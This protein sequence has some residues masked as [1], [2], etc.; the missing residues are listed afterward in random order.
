MRAGLADQGHGDEDRAWRAHALQVHVK[1][2]R[3]AGVRDVAAIDDVPYV[4]H[5]AV[6]RLAQLG[7]AR[8]EP[9]QLAPRIARLGVR[10][11]A[12]EEQSCAL[13]LGDGAQEPA[14]RSEVTVRYIEVV[15]GESQ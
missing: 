3:E 10:D 11:T 12:D 6:E 13:Q 4:P 9:S 8:D 5:P 1:P 7:E 15:F 2:Q 14:W